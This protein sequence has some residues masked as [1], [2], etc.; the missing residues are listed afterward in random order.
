M[1]DTA[2]FVKQPTRLN[3]LLK[4]HRIEEEAPYRIVGTVL[5]PQIDYENFATDLTVDREYIARNAHLCG[6]V[7]G[8]WQ[9]LLIRQ[10]NAKTGILV[11]PEAESWVG[12][13]AYYGQSAPRLPR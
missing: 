4:P 1:R 3:N 10:Q 8:V 12:Y 9:C 11:M 2:Y 5:L 7:D 13:A 6:I